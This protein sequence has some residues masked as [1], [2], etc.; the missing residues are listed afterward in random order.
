M[1]IVK[2]PITGR[3]PLT[4]LNEP[5]QALF[6]FYYAFNNRDLEIMSENWNQSDEIAMDN[7]LGGIKR[8]WNEIK[9]VYEKIF[10][11]S[12]RVYVEL[13]DYTI[14]TSKEMFY[15]VGRE[16]GY[17]QLD[18]TKI[19]LMIRTSRIF[20]NINKRWKQVHHHGSIDNP[21][22]LKRYQSAVLGK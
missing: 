6:Q 4:D 1:E 20:R 11:G 19:D 12:A 5:Y 17:F 9:Q 2:T 8:G 10:Y 13:Y 3:E 16:Q 7:P 21:E 22:L 18:N 14:H 15:V